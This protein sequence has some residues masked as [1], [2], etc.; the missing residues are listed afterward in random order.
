MLVAFGN[1]VDARRS[2]PVPVSPV[3]I[4]ERGPEHMKGTART[5]TARR[6]IP[7]TRD[8]TLHVGD[9]VRTTHTHTHTHRHNAEPFTTRARPHEDGRR[10]CARRSR[11]GGCTGIQ[12]RCQRNPY[13]RF[14]KTRLQL[15]FVHHNQHQL[16][17][18]LICRCVLS[19]WIQSVF[20][21]DRAA[22]P[23]LVKSFRTI[24]STDLNSRRELSLKAVPLTM[25]HSL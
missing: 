13:G 20:H 23:Y 9:Y 8:M 16:L 1:S 12:G 14:Q 19:M 2:A 24:P 11:I 10:E 3:P 21:S 7:M 17:L 18:C 22:W 15:P 6:V 25:S 4:V 5:R